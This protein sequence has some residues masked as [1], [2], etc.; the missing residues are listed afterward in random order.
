MLGGAGFLPSTRMGTTKVSTSM[1]GISIVSKHD[2]AI[3]TETMYGILRVPTL[4]M[5]NQQNLSR[6]TIH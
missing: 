5:E 3:R 1:V 6:Y 4:T 2:E